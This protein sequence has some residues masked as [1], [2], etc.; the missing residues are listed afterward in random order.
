M[1]KQK[2]VSGVI[3]D[4]FNY[5]FMILMVV[6][7]L[8]PFWY[9]VVCSMSDSNLLLGRQGT[10]IFPLGFN[11]NA[12]RLVLSNPNIISGYRTTVFVLFAGTSLNIFMTCLG[13]YVLSRKQFAIKRPMMLM[14][15]FTM[16]FSGGMIPNYLLIYN[17]LGLGNSLLALILPG[18]I[19]T[20]NLIIL[21]TNFASIPDSMEE[22]AKID[23]ASDYTILFRIIIPLSIPTIAVLIL[24][25]GVGHW[26]SWFNA[27][28]YIR[29]RS[30]YPLQLILR[31]IILL[32]S[33]DQMLGD[34][35]SVD[36]YSIGE[37]IKYSTIVV[38]TIPILV[39]YPFIQKYFVKGVM[40]GAIK[41]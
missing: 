20:W 13:A 10:L 22:S 5:V 14:I 3:F 6:I 27:M 23:G 36:K 39:V 9:V 2:T 41:G 32:N 24:F 28:L 8:Y 29:E 1:V 31:E 16:Y 12:Y 4:I 25:Y 30:K 35:S 40:V 21:R 19:S 37:S 34:T 38:A 17:Y 15:V 11:I 26:N 18:M 33:M 7:T